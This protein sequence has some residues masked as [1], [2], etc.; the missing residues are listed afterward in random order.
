MIAMIKWANLLLDCD[1]SRIIFCFLA[2]VCSS[3]VEHSVTFNTLEQKSTQHNTRIIISYQPSIIV[4]TIL[5]LLSKLAKPWSW[6][7]TSWKMFSPGG[8]GAD[9]HYHI[10][11]NSNHDHND[12]HKQ[13]SHQDKE[14]LAN[15]LNFQALLGDRLEVLH[16]EIEINY[17]LGSPSLMRMR[18][19]IGNKAMM[20]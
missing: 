3:W 11:M 14:L 8:Q 13:C 1:E 12:D 18:L 7:W 4:I 5:T 19:S 20:L 17:L 16:L 9:R 10:I 6:S 2:P 15:D